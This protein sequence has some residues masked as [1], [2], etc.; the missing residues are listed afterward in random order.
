M[1]DCRVH[2]CL[3][4][5]RG[6]LRL[7]LSSGKIKIGGFS[8]EVGT[9]PSTNGSTTQPIALTTVEHCM[10]AGQ[11]LTVLSS[12]E[13]NE[14][15]LLTPCDRDAFIYS[16]TI[17]GALRHLEDKADSKRTWQYICAVSCPTAISDHVDNT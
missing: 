7:I 13:I 16:G 12:F 2:D 10:S 11:T 4:L 5:L 8:L 9:P 6:A 3:P 17:R 1:L 15:G 14:D